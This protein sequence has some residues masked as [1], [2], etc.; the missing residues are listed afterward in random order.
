MKKNYLKMSVAG[1]ALCLA[2][3]SCV[4]Y[5][6]IP[7]VVDPG[8]PEEQSASV[9]CGG[10]F[11]LVAFNGISLPT[12]VLTPIMGENMTVPDGWTYMVV[13]AGESTTITG[14]MYYARTVGKTTHTFRANG[15]E[16]S[17]IFDAGKSYYIES[18]IDEDEDG[19]LFTKRVTFKESGIRIYDI[20]EGDTPYLYKYY[21][22]DKDSLLAFIP[23][24]TQPSFKTKGIFD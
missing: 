1:I 17:Y 22:V 19:F 5:Q 14:N 2:L 18:Y 12:K 21:P 13:P 7:L 3:G 24:T 4:T 15:M 20:S 6:N 10:S 16:F 23:F 8:V 9:Y 11:W